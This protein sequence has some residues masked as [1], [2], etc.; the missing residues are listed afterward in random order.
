MYFMFVAVFWKKAKPSQ[1]KH[2]SQDGQNP[3]SKSEK[4]NVVPL[5]IG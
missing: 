5:Q 1:I 3:H 4:N 2:M